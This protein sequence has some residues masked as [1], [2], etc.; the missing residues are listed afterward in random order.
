MILLVDTI[1]PESSINLGLALS[2]LVPTL[3]AAAAALVAVVSM[4]GKLDKLERLQERVALE[5][6]KR[7][8]EDRQR[9]TKLEEWRESAKE[10]LAVV[11]DRQARSGTFKTVDCDP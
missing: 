6:N 9:I 1:T 11:H 2:I 8:D 10:R 3:G 4:R 5:Q 7:A